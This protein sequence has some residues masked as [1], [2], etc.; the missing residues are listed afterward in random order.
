MITVFNQAPDLNISWTVWAELVYQPQWPAYTSSLHTYFMLK[1][2]WVCQAFLFPQCHSVFQ[3]I[4]K[5]T[6]WLKS[7]FPR[8]SNTYSNTKLYSA[9]KTTFFHAVPWLSLLNNDWWV[10]DWSSVAWY[11]RQQLIKSERNYDCVLVAGYYLKT[12]PKTYWL[13]LHQTHSRGYSFMIVP[14]SESHKTI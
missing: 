1:E 7:D 2:K 13:P 10:F 8:T 11:Q 3:F 12:K 6:L 14:F 4:E 9:W 5:K